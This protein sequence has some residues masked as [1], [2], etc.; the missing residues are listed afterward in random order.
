M[1]KNKAK[2]SK[3]LDAKGYKVEECIWE[4]IGQAAEMCGPDGGWMIAYWP[5][6]GRDWD[7]SSR[8]FSS[9]IL[10]YNINEVMEQINDLPDALYESEAN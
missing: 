2:I 6:E 9:T 3:A 7:D 1:S 4:P 8:I 10:G 5:N